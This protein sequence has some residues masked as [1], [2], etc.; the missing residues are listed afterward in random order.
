MIDHRVYDHTSVP[1]TIEGRFGLA[2][3]TE[4]DKQAAHVTGLLTLSDPRTDAP[5][6]LPS[7]AASGVHFGFLDS[8]ESDFEKVLMGLGLEA[9][10]PVDPAL[11]GF[12]HVALL[13]KLSTSAPS[14]RGALISEAGAVRSDAD[15]VRYILHARKSIL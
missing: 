9:G 11:A 4:R 6:T 8:L 13:R 10:K 15:A 2:N 12:V 5:Q 1:A 14:D 3:L 7:P